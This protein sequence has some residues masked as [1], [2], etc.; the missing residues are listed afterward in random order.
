MGSY[1]W[2]KA[3]GNPWCRSGFS[4]EQPSSPVTAWGLGTSLALAQGEGEERGATGPAGWPWEVCG[5]HGAGSPCAWECIHLLACTS[6]C[7]FTCIKVHLDVC[8][9]VCEGQ[10][11]LCPC[12]LGYTLCVRVCVHVCTI[13]VQRQHVYVYVQV[14]GRY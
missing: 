6:M 1:A 7:V 2:C 5:E 8:A 11:L 10:R 9:C 4:Q 14:T 3:L 13:C 12:T